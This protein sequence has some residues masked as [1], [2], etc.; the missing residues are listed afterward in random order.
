MMLTVITS[1]ITSFLGTRF[2]K[3][4]EK[5]N[6]VQGCKLFFCNVPYCFVVVASNFVLFLSF[7]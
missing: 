5:T 3:L 6:I 7:L 2:E 1:T 4:N